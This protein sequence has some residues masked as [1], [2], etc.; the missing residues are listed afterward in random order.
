M[1]GPEQKEEIQIKM[2]PIVS[3]AQVSLNLKFLGFYR[4]K[5][6]AVKLN[7]GGNVYEYPWKIDLG[8]TC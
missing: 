5:D 6:K 2:L 4:K 1:L 3:A 7:Y 8:S